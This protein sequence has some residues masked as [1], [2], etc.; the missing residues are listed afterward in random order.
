MTRNSHHSM[1]RTGTFWNK[2]D[3]DLCTAMLAVSGWISVVAGVTNVSRDAQFVSGYDGLAARRREDCREPGRRR[4]DVQGDVREVVGLLRGAAL[5][6][7]VVRVD[8]EL[9]RVGA[10]G[11]NA[12]NGHRL[13][14][15]RG[16]REAVHPA[17]RDRAASIKVRRDGDAGRRG[18]ALV[19]D[20]GVHGEGLVL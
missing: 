14:Q 9:E 15:G 7:R 20:Q 4:L 1:P 13:I 5:V 3:E 19:R 17:V 12:L 8:D 10:D 18:L 6:D 11:G 2:K 16:D